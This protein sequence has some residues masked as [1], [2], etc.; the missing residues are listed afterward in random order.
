MKILQLVRIIARV[1]LLL[2]GTGAAAVGAL[3]FAPQG[4]SGPTRV[5]PASALTNV[6]T[7]AAPMAESGRVVR[8]VDGDTYDVLAGG[9][10]YR[11][12][13]LARRVPVDAP[14][15]DQPLATKRATRWRGC[16]G[17][18]GWCG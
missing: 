18:S 6:A 13:L 9:V 5:L 7:P 4:C 14:E 3:H 16:W 8:V 2:A 12:R 10:R 1:L 11:V 15:P 17:R